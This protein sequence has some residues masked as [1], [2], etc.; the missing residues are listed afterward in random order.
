MKT[1]KT[2]L[3]TCCLGLALAVTGCGKETQV[4]MSD[5]QRSEYEKNQF[6]TVTVE[7]GDK[8]PDFVLY[9]KT[10]E[11][12]K[13]VYSL[14]EG[15]YDVKKLYVSL[16]DHV[17]KGQLLLELDAKKL[18]DTVKACNT[19]VRK[20]ELLLAYYTKLDADDTS[21]K[22]K[23]KADVLK[24]TNA[25]SLAKIRL[26]E[27][28]EKLSHTTITAQEE[29]DIVLLNS[30]VTSGHVSAGMELMC[31]AFGTEKYYAE[32]TE[33]YEF[34]VG[35]EYVAESIFGNVPMVVS[36][37]SQD[38]DKTRLELATADGNPIIN[39][40]DSLSIT[41]HKSM[42]SGVVY[43]SGN[44]IHETEDGRKFVYVMDGDGFNKVVMVETGESIGNSVIIK[45]GL[46]GGEE[47]AIR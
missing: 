47:V 42:L 20:E 32:T 18:E 45:S 30:S 6:E 13:V 15:E 10:E 7:K 26:S 38:G 2:I 21:G 46:N 16:G 39:G 37:V 1:D 9:V 36:G 35:D 40:T 24:H 22:D 25:L 28:N 31:E 8:E 44:A 17:E 33:N 19:D 14:D 11:R 43:V 29:G 5:I 23:Y 3:L 41:I 27:A 34:N 4:L 12:D